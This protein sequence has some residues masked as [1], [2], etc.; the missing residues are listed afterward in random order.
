M[1]AATI[2]EIKKELNHCSNDDIVNLCLRLG[3]FKKEN[4]E[5]LTYL[6][7]ENSNEDSYI[8][9]IKI[10]ID[11]GFETINTASY[12]YIKKSVRRILRRIRTYCRYSGKKETE[13]ELLLYF[14]SVLKSMHPTY[15]QSPA[16][17][18]LY[19]RQ[20]LNIKKSVSA[21][22][23]DLQYDYNLILESI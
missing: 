8:A 6:L 2:T 4:K 10:E 15:R 13:V 16:L 1:K 11:Y 5:L 9:N 22:H 14:C 7:F 18:N 3:R 17:V 19:N 20:I 21:L 12:F 23:E